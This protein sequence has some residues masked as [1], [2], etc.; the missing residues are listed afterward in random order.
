MFKLEYKNKIDLILATIGLVFGLAIICLYFISPTMH[1]IIIGS[2]IFLSSVFYLMTMH[3]SNKTVEHE[4]TVEQKR[5][6]DI[7]FFILFNLSLIIWQISEDRTFYYFLLISLCAGVL[8][9]SIYLSNNKF[10]YY[11]QIIKIMILSFQIKYLIYIS[12]GYLPGID[13]YI[14]A[15]SNELLAITGNISVLSDSKSLYFP[16]MNIH[17]AIMQIISNLGVKEASVFMFIVPLIISTIFLYLVA[18][19]IFGEKIALFSIVFL[20]FADFHIYYGFIMTTTTYGIILFYFLMYL[21]YKI[22][23][24]QRTPIFTSFTILLIVILVNT[25][26]VSSFIFIVAFSMLTLAFLIYE[27]FY[28]YAPTYLYK[29]LVNISFI[30][31]LSRWIYAK[32]AHGIP[33]FDQIVL[34]LISSFAKTTGV[35]NRPERYASTSI[36]FLESFAN[37]F[38]LLIFLFLT[39]VGTFA[40][41]SCPQRN[42]IKFAYIFTMVMMFAITFV[43]PLFGL[44]NIIPS[45]WF[46]FVYFFASMLASFALFYIYNKINKPYI[47]I[48]FIFLTI[49]FFVFFM[50]SST[51]ANQDSPLWLENSTPSYIYSTAEITAAKTI[52]QYSE[53]VFSD[54]FYGSSV[55]GVYL[56]IDHRRFVD[57][58]S[59]DNRGKDIFLWRRYFFE[60]PIYTTSK[61]EVLGSD[62]FNQLESENKIY[63]N[64]YVIGYYLS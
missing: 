21:L 60:R 23:Y 39:V 14:H 31:L 50:S 3:I 13:P 29:G 26:A 55:L 7:L 63:N 28:E 48:S 10:D 52:V 59:L 1:L 41:L 46:V 6:F 8:G 62:V 47:R 22:F 20:N 33:F 42:K 4:T 40:S 56:G 57:I 51:I 35:L 12:A 19:T 64:K 38:G 45:R 17:E 61:L 11:M 49:V 43:F 32:F 30:A 54:R 16:I 24:L 2:A 18:R 27:Y 15:K 25:H 58:N 36:P 53:N 34:W 37:S 9:C 44:R 5:L